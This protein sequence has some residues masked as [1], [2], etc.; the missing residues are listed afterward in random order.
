MES[1]DI[2]EE[3]EDMMFEGGGEFEEEEVE[4]EVVEFDFD[5]EFDASK[6]FDLSRDESPIEK[7]DAESWFYTAP[8]YPPS[9]LTF[10]N[11][12]AKD[13]RHPK[14]KQVMKTFASRGS[15]LMKPTASQLAKQN[16]REV[17]NSNRL[18]ER[19]QQKSSENPVV[20]NQ[21]AKRQKL[22]RG[23][24]PKV[25]DTKQQTSYIHKQSKKGAPVDGNSTHVKLKITIP[26]QPD[27]E[28]A[29]RT[30]RMRPKNGT[31]RVEQVKTTASVFRAR[32]LNRKILEAPSLPL[33]KKSTPRL[34]AFQEFHLKT[35]ERAMQH[36]F[37]ASSATPHSNKSD[38]V[39]Q[40]TKARPITLSNTVDSTRPHSVT[41]LRQ[42]GSE[43]TQNFKARPLNKKI[44]SSK[45]D[46]GVFRNTKRE[47][48]IPMEFNFSTDKRSQYHPPV[49]LFDKLSLTSELQQNTGSKPKMPRSTF[50]PIKGSKENTMNSFQQ[51]HRLMNVVK[52]KPKRFGGKQMQCGVDGEINEVGSRANMRMISESTEAGPDN[53]KSN[54][55]HKYVER[56]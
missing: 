27:L 48:T 12:M 24:L 36:S 25:I 47:A 39:L 21:A 46:I 3:M 51:D 42:E 4:V 43:T 13:I 50:I 5:Y 41:A 37:A 29:H 17:P 38:K 40:T 45:G 54:L 30:Q 7:Q 10:Y 1:S 19:S 9:R 44:F 23:H 56:P 20:E 34:P 2:D 52:E 6:Y 28:T 15:T 31:E 22:E 26:R 16:R 8:N 32:P 53:S 18:L 35:A 11:H 49:E 33:L 55:P 14:P